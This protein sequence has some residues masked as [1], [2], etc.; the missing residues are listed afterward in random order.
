MANGVY[1]MNYEA[2][3]CFTE[4]ILI[5]NIHKEEII[6]MNIAMQKILGTKPNIE[7]FIERNFSNREQDKKI[8]IDLKEKGV[9]CGVFSFAFDIEL[10][11]KCVWLEMNQTVLYT[12]KSLERD[13]VEAV[14]SGMV[15]LDIEHLKILYTNSECDKIFNQENSWKDSDNRFK[16]LLYEEDQEFVLNEIKRGIKEQSHVDI[17]FRIK[18]REKEIKWIRLFGRTHTLQENRLFFCANLKDLSAFREAG[19]RIHMEKM[20]LHR[21]NHLSEEVVFRLDLKKKIAQFMGKSFDI[22]G[23]YTTIENFPEPI[24]N[25]KLVYEED[26]PIFQDMVEAFY[27]DIQKSFEMRYYMSNGEIEWQKVVYDFVRNDDGE[28]LFVTGK[29]INIHEHKKLEEQA[30]IDLLT[31]FYNKITTENEIEYLLKQSDIQTDTHTLF[32]IDLDYFKSVNDNLGHHFGDIVLHNVATDIRNCFREDDIFG[33]IGG[34]E[35]IVLMKQCDDIEA[36]MMRAYEVCKCLDQT[37]QGETNSYSISASIGIAMYPNDALHFEELYQKGDKALYQSKANGKNCYT[38]YQDDFIYN[39]SCII[40]KIDTLPQEVYAKL[41][42]INYKI[43]STVFHLLYETNDILISLKTVMA[44]LGK[45]YHVDRCY[46]FETSDN[47]TKYENRYCWV[48]EELLSYETERSF[49]DVDVLNAIYANNLDNDIFYTNDIY[50]I[51]DKQATCVLEEDRVESIFLIRLLKKTD[52]QMFFG[53][54]DC[55]EKREWSSKDIQ[56]LYHTTK[57]IFS[58]LIHYNVVKK[59]KQDISKLENRG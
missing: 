25:M 49:V 9:F 2:M 12:I 17:E 35:F 30:K 27:L 29:L 58:S 20:L 56:T 26:I 48:N 52:F 8:E 51:K 1:H 55:K 50:S 33:R 10:D 34:D 15:V 22:F 47:E 42:S 11:F 54:D 24:L 44:Y 41:D 5:K 46:I 28:P 6:F 18:D 23:E 43:L 59:L 19:D 37:F 16:I 39:N 14:P 40:P 53:M 36:I 38:R 13:L 31:G 21:M 4:P 57:A 7:Y 45:V 32:I 3:N